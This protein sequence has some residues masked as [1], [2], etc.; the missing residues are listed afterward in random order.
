MLAFV[1]VGTGEIRGCLAAL[2]RKEVSESR[3]IMAGDGWGG[4]QLMSPAQLSSGEL[5]L[6]HFLSIPDPWAGEMGVLE[7]DLHFCPLPLSSQEQ[8]TE[9]SRKGL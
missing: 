3:Y 6:K 7:V 4:G 9:T 2:Q 1:G 5:L 8:G